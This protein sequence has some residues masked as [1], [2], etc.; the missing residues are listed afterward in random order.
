MVKL[1]PHARKPGMLFTRVINFPR[2]GFWILSCQEPP[3]IGRDNWY[4]TVTATIAVSLKHFTSR[5]EP[6][7]SVTVA[8]MFWKRE[9]ITEWLQ[10]NDVFVHV[11]P[12]RIEPRPNHRTVRAL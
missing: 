12:R 9:G 8:L 4:P 5:G 3:N 1:Q 7:A 6:N 11:D 2:N 10:L